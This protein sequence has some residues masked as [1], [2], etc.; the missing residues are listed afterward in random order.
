[1]ESVRWG[2]IGV[3]NVTEAKSGPGLQRAERSELVAVMR[4]TGDKA[5]DYARRHGVARWY[6]DAD[7]L[8]ADPDVDAVY[9]ATP[10]D[11]HRDYALRV[12]AAGKP[13]YVEKPMAR[14]AAE[15]DAMI[16]G[17]ALAGVPLFVAYYR[18]AMPRFRRVREL[19]DGGA[20][21]TP[22]AVAVRLQRRAADVV[23][24]VPGDTTESLPWRLRPEISGGGLFVDLGSHTLDLL[25][26][27]LGPVT[28][29]TGVAANQGAHYGAEDLVAGVFEFA[30][31]VCGTGLW[32]FDT[33]ENRDEIE[34][35]GT[36]GTLTF[37]TFTTEPLRLRGPDGDRLVSAGYP[38][39]VQQPLIQTVVD[40]LTGRGTCPSTGESAARTARVVDTLLRDYRR[41]R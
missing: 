20:I 23:A 4:R 30:S 28:R 10:P 41:Q 33:A 40:E 15:C 34:I 24:S 26:W 35:V 11:S 5:A 13:V 17:C 27:L 6:D 1:M 32:A 8:I 31:G 3:G 12:A 38:E 29:V 22:R 16:D 19:L 39:V 25:D 14:T 36:T 7:A 2:I 18:R 37:S 9:I 21:G